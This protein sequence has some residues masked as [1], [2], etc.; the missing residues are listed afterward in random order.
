M[1]GWPG[2]RSC[3]SAVAAVLAWARWEAPNSTNEL[4]QPIWEGATGSPYHGALWLAA[5][6][7]W[8]IA[9][10][11][12]LGGTL[13]IVVRHGRTRD[14]AFLFG[15]ACISGLC[16]ADDYWQLHNPV[17]RDWSGLPS[18]V[19]LAAY[20]VVILTWLLLFQV[21]I[22]R[23]DV[24]VL[25]VA[26]ACFAVWLTCNVAPSFEARNSLEIASKLAGAAGWALYVT[27]TSLSLSRQRR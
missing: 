22:R 12:A 19:L 6:A 14:A 23:S 18:S 24:A 21:E 20:A 16:L 4:I 7:C 17:F 3:T 10:V 5:L 26:L 11:A 1:H 8:A 9:L 2:S 27:L 15:A 13:T 25:V